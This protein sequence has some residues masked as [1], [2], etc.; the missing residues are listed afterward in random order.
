M[1]RSERVFVDTNYFVAL[2]NPSD[3]L[4]ARAIKIGKEIDAARTRL[5]ISNFIFLETVTVLA[6]RRGKDTAREAGKYLL[7]SGGVEIIHIDEVLQRSA[8]EIFQALRKKDMSFVDA[9][10]IAILK[11]EDMSCLITF[12]RA[13]FNKLARRYSFRIYA[14]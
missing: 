12:D 7:D 3:A 9:S 13:D 4:H 14:E 6:Q 2:F 11:V 5:V 10:I 8:W 1:E